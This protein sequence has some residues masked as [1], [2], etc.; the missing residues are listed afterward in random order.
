MGSVY[1]E[2][3]NEEMNKQLEEARSELR[4]IRFSYAVARSMSDPSRVKKL[5]RNIARILTIKNERAAGK[6]DIKPKTERKAKAKDKKKK[7]EATA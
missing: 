6:S 4:E 2:L 1:H 7:E 5:K 3:T